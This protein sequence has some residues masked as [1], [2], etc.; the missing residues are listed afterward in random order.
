[1]NGGLSPSTLTGDSPK[2]GSYTIIANIGSNTCSVT[3][4]GSETYSGSIKEIPVYYGVSNLGKTSENYKSTLLTSQNKSITCSGTTTGTKTITGVYPCF[5]NR[6]TSL[7]SNASIKLVKDTTIFEIENIP[8][9]KTENKPFMFE[10]P[11]NRTVVVKSKPSILEYNYYTNISGNSLIDS[12]NTSGT[13]IPSSYT[14]RI[15]VPAEENFHFKLQFPEVA[16]IN[17]I[18]KLNTNNNQWENFNA[19]KYNIS[20]G[21]NKNGNSYKQFETKGSFLGAGSYEF[22]FK[23]PTYS[24]VNDYMTQN[25]QKEI[26]GTNYDYIRLITNKTAEIVSRQLTLSKKTSL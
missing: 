14:I 10:F 9:E 20:S 3:S 21:F 8:S 15:N 22:T 18:K 7:G 5:H 16:E 19:D 2:T 4:E 13:K 12:I 1:M 24:T 23:T 25:F 17:T 26:N 11:N 6:S